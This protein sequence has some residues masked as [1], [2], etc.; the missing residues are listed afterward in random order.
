MKLMNIVL[1]ISAAFVSSALAELDIPR[2][3]FS[4]GELDE[5]KAYALEQEKPLIFMNT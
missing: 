4:L 3:S 5:A 2:K 1:V